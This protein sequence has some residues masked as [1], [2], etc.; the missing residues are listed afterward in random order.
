LHD[1]KHHL[2]LCATGSVATIKLPLI[3]TTLLTRHTSSSLSI[4]IL[5]TPSAAQFLQ[6]QSPEQPSLSALAAIP[7]VDGIYLD[8]DEWRRPWTRGASILHIELRRWADLMVIAPLSANSLAKVAGGMAEGLV[9]SVVRAWDSTGEID[10]PRELRI[11]VAPAMNTAMWEHPVTRKHLAVLEGE[12]GV[13]NGGWI[14]VLRPVEK[15]LACGDTGSGAMREWKQ[16]VDVIE[17]RLGL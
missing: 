4:R 12:W 5:L 1:N 14:E 10:G 9:A 6:S 8:A 16:I 15:T 17:Q 3:I 7:G 13:A 2:L 11:V